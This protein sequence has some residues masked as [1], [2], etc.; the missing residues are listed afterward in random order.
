MSQRYESLYPEWQIPLEDVIRETDREKLPEKVQKAEAKISDRLR[1]IQ[2][3]SD[4][5]HEQ[6]AIN[7]A[8][9]VIKA[10]KRER[11]GS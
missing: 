10:I 7:R 5:R 11:L 2:K 9:F 6:D 4:G 8:L 3:S 1:Q